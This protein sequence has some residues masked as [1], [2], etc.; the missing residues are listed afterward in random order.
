MRRFNPPA[1]RWI[2]IVG[3]AALGAVPSLAQS[4]EF[5]AMWISR[6]EWPDLDPNTCRAR[7]DSM[8]AQLLA[9][10]FNAV[11]FQVRGQA[12]TLYPSPEETWSPLLNETNPGWDP[13]AYAIQSAHA[14]GIAF[15][16][17][18]NSHTCWQ[19]NPAS[20]HTLPA[21]ANHVFYQHCNAADPAHRDWLH[22]SS[23]SNPVQ[24][25]ESDYVWFAPGVPA[26]QAHFRRQ[27][28]HVAANYDVDGI[29]FDRIRTPGSASPSYDPISQA[30]FASAQSNPDNLDFTRWTADQV[31]RLVT[32][33]YA[34]VAVVRPDV[35]FSAAVFPEPNTAPTAQHQDAKAW[36]ERGGLDLIV[37]MMYSSGGAGS[38]WDARLQNWL[39]GASGRLVVAGQITSVG[40]S[41]LVDQISLTRTR[42]AAGNSVFSYTSFSWWDA[43][44][45][46][47]YQQTAALPAMPWK[48]NPM[49]GFIYGYV[50]DANGTPIVDAQVWRTGAAYRALSCADGFYSLLLA[51]AGPTSLFAQHASHAGPVVHDIMVQVGVGTRRDFVLG[52][53]PAP[54]IAEVTPNPAPAYRG[55][56]YRQQLVLTQGSAA[57]WQLL[58]GPPEAAIDGNGLVAGW[59]PT[60]AMSGELH[61]FGAR[62]TNDAGSDEVWWTALVS[63]T[64][65]CARNRFT[66]FEGYEV[67]ATV[68]FRRPRFSGSTAQHLA[69]APDVAAVTD[70]VTPFGGTQCYRLEFAFLDTNPNRWARITTNNAASVPNPT[71]ELHRPLRIRLRLDSGRLRL[72]IGVRETGTTAD[73]GAN[74]GTTGTIEWIGATGNNAGTPQMAW[75]IEAMPGVWQTF[76]FDPLTQPI[77]AMTGDGI[78]WSPTNRGVFEQLAFAPVDSAGPF[79]IYVDDVDLLCDRPPFGDFNRDWELT[80]AD[81]G[82][83]EMCMWGPDIA[84]GTPCLDGDANGDQDVDLADLAAFQ[85][86]CGD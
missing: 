21:N 60:N 74:G 55:Q 69:T 73:I 22:H 41:T 58:A 12:D 4:P 20:A 53:A 2:L 61:E 43:Y 29:H 76:V 82:G 27:V 37:P 56:E 34:A 46:G 49:T 31:T 51:P 66:D 62:A 9:A 57:S 36:A 79:V 32:D 38:L 68:L 13:L 35:A 24:F 50:T 52:G 15:H 42:G 39:A 7:I 10:R 23:A 72:C 44:A 19:S 33:C 25:N 78:I 6:F 3:A 8:M 54:L 16:A 30:R 70:A 64:E 18:I 86:V 11:F 84:L 59:R 40:L 80:A 28:L 81:L 26:Y 45:N 17:Y 83:Y 71:V 65:P 1:L 63:P 47:V 14:H 75:T 77:T 85:A 5:R 67:G 48:T